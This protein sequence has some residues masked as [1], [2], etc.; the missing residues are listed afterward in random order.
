M[1][2]PD[3]LVPL[4]RQEWQIEPLPH[5][6]RFPAEPFMGAAVPPPVVPEA[7]RTEFRDP[8][9]MDKKI[10]GQIPVLLSGKFIRNVAGDS[11]LVGAVLSLA[12]AQQPPQL[13]QEAPFLR[14]ADQVLGRIESRKVR[15]CPA[16]GG[17]RKIL[18]SWN[19]GLSSISSQESTLTQSG[20]MEY[21][22]RE[23]SALSYF[24]AR[25]WPPVGRIDFA[26]I[27]LRPVAG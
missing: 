17:E 3:R 23:G 25:T 16:G 5:R 6:F 7:G 18:Q 13:V 27:R 4:G 2:G 20:P 10:D 1:L 19:C 14:I 22:L 11:H 9:H 15:L 24:R 21:G 26:K 12:H 8:G